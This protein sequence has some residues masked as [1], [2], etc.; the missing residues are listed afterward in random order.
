MSPTYNAGPEFYAA[1]GA[2]ADVGYFAKRGYSPHGLESGG[3]EHKEKKSFAVGQR[4]RLNVVSVFM[5]LFVPWAV[6]T[7]NFAL[8]S[9]PVHYENPTFVYLIIAASFASICI[10]GLFK[11]C[12]HRRTVEIDEKEPSWLQYLVLTSMVAWVVGVVLGNI[13][14]LSIWSHSST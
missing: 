1:Y 7:V 2:A 6:F 11:C 12:E 3:F 8:L 13:N 9:F 14:Y 4:K 10:L 5:G